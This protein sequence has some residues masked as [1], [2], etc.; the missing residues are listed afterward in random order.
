MEE[1]TAHQ[2]GPASH[3]SIKEIY[4][5]IAALLACIMTQMGVHF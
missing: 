5:Y 3:N 1:K 2:F 4:L